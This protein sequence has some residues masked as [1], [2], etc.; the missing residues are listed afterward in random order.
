MRRRPPLQTLLAAALLAVGASPLMAQDVAPPQAFDWHADPV[1]ATTPW[2]QAVDVESTRLILS[3]TTAPEYTSP[4]VDHLPLA[5]GVLSPTAHFGHPVGKP[6]VLHRTEEIHAYFRALDASTD[7][8]RFTELGPTEEGNRLGLVQVGSAANLAR[9]EEIRRG[10][11]R[12]ADPRTSDAGEAA[13]LIA[14]L[15]VVYLLTAGL[16]STETGPPEMVMEL[17]YRLAASD[18][19]LVRGI[20]DDVVTLIVPVTEP[21]GRN[22]VAVNA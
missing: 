16:H 13:R 12:L 20:R 19:P 3:W 10:Y 6:G 15:P 2:G 1:P 22:R 4:L 11:R 21:D 14:D 18:D 17:A 9:L 5:A 8:V 7:R